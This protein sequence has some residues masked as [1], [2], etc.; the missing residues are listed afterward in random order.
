MSYHSSR[1]KPMIAM[2]Y[3]LSWLLFFDSCTAQVS[4]LSLNLIPQIS[5][6]FH[7]I[8]FWGVDGRNVNHLLVLAVFRFVRPQA[9][10]ALFLLCRLQPVNVEK[11]LRE[12]MGHDKSND[13][14]IKCQSKPR[15]RQWSRRLFAG[16]EIRVDWLEMNPLKAKM[17]PSTW[18]MRSCF[19]LLQKKTKE[20]TLAL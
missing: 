3:F 20:H 17:W 2:L 7:C 8:D 5:L 4:S 14:K 19:T 11:D 1:Y 16:W 18:L 13:S 6:L 9:K 10:P 15:R 12:S